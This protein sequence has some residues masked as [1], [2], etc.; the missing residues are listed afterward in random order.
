MNREELRAAIEE[1]AIDEYGDIIGS[2]IKSSEAKAAMELSA[3]NLET[4]QYVDPKMLNQIRRD[5]RVLYEVGEI[6]NETHDTGTMLQKVSECLGE[7]TGA[8]RVLGI[9]RN[10]LHMEGRGGAEFEVK[11]SWF[12]PELAVPG[13]ETM[14][15]STA[16]VRRVV[17]EKI[18][19]YT[20]AI[21]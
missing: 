17:G 6:V 4:V 19:V 8:D 2:K 21:L 12:R 3:A 13:E 14:G 10:N 20:P 7:A 5:L 9:Y 1:E 18:G 15:F 11:A 16:I